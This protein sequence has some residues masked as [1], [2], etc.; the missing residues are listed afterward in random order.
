MNEA[1]SNIGIGAVGTTVNHEKT[2]G[3]NYGSGILGER[4]GDKGSGPAG[5]VSVH[6]SIR[7]KYRQIEF[8]VRDLVARALSPV[9]I[10]LH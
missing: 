1:N 9:E 10:L 7:E 3:T 6:P 5:L 2:S 8:R 4:P